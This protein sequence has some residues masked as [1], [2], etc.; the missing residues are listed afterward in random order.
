[1]AVTMANIIPNYGD[2]EWSFIKDKQR[3]DRAIARFHQ[4]PEYKGLD[5]REYVTLAPSCLVFAAQI[6]VWKWYETILPMDAIKELHPL[7]DAINQYLTEARNSVS[8]TGDELNLTQQPRRYFET[9]DFCYDAVERRPEI[10][11]E[12]RKILYDDNI[13]ITIDGLENKAASFVEHNL[14]DTEHIM[15]GLIGRE[16][17]L[18]RIEN[19]LEQMDLVTIWGQGGTGK[20]ALALELAWKFAEA[21]QRN[22]DPKFDLIAFASMKNKVLTF[23][24]I[25]KQ[26]E[27]HPTVETI[28]H[29]LT[30]DFGFEGNDIFDVCKEFQSLIIIDNLESVEIDKELIY[31]IEQ[32]KKSKPDNSDTN[33]KI[34]ITTRRDWGVM[35]GGIECPEM[36]QDEAEEYFVKLVKGHRIPSLVKEEEVKLRKFSKQFGRKPDEIFWGVKFL[37]RDGDLDEFFNTK[38]DR[39]SYCLGN[40]VGKLNDNEIILLKAIGSMNNPTLAEIEEIK[41]TASIPEKQDI[42]D[43]LTTLESSALIRR[44]L[45]KQGNVHVYKLCNGVAEFLANSETDDDILFS[46]RLTKKIEQ[47]NTYIPNKNT[48]IFSAYN[49]SGTENN[50]E[51]AIAASKLLK[52]ISSAEKKEREGR[53]NEISDEIRQVNLLKN[54]F[55]N[56]FELY[57]VLGYL[58]YLFAG[59]SVFSYKADAAYR[60]AFTIEEHNEDRLHYFY[61]SFLLESSEYEKACQHFKPLIEKY[62]KHAGIINVYAKALFWHADTLNS[63]S[64]FKESKELIKNSIIENSKKKH[65]IGAWINNKNIWAFIDLH[66]KRRMTDQLY[67]FEDNQAVPTRLSI[68][69]KKK[70]LRKAIEDLVWITSQEYRELWFQKK[71]IFSN[72]NTFKKTYLTLLLNIDHHE[73]SCSN[74]PESTLNRL[75][76]ITPDILVLLE[77]N[78]IYNREQLAEKDAYELNKIGIDIDLSRDIIMEARQQKNYFGKNDYQEE[79]I[80]KNDLLKV[81]TNLRDDLSHSDLREILDAVNQLRHS[82][83]FS[84]IRY[85]LESALGR[86]EKKTLQNSDEILGSSKS[87]INLYVQ[88]TIDV[89]FEP[90][91]EGMIRRAYKGRIVKDHD[92]SAMQ[93]QTEDSYIGVGEIL[94]GKIVNETSDACI[95]EHSDGDQERFWLFKNHIISKLHSSNT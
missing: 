70:I 37:D 6:Q 66:V 49:F 62:P 45:D 22:E 53:K 59:K 1:M 79:E 17:L 56:Y 24:G 26:G 91:T 31:F 73:E 36:S 30:K 85:W 67:Y 47:I 35:S 84:L 86:K 69:D 16:N 68:N 83:Y 77:S 4:K 51:H 13:E 58:E 5:Y 10:Y 40:I 2:P 7:T 38:K 61:G 12:V 3:R 55:E 25:E 71:N 42:Q 63:D 19:E 28:K 88:F 94:E 15:T 74:Q 72:L 90:R 39:L 50:K 65:T 34:I 14:I 80:N 93:N 41:P 60:K 82:D 75:N 33:T 95:V 64:L 48:D 57:R 20:T 78:G 11:V 29:E 54:K 92:Q 32:L 44:N 21:D 23:K 9:Q 89:S 76:F 43:L 8:H 18:A 27:Q 87:Y 46:R 52:L 81:I